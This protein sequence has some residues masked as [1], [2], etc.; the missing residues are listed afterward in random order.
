MRH[1]EAEQASH[2]PQTGALPVLTHPLVPNKSTG[3]LA[4]LCE[5]AGKHSDDVVQIRNKIKRQVWQRT[6]ET[7]TLRTVASENLTQSSSILGNWGLAEK[8]SGQPSTKRNMI[9]KMLRQAASK[10]CFNKPEGKRGPRET[11]LPSGL[12]SEIKCKVK[13]VVNLAR[14]EKSHLSQNQ[15]WIVGFHIGF[16]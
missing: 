16:L 15:C 14:P 5:L 10:E 4:Y 9:R 1:R 6:E 2:P 12:C 3:N 13:D 7:M 8:E 11:Y